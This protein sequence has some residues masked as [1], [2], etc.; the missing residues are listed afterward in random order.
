MLTALDSAFWDQHGCLSSRVHFVETGGKGAHSPVDY[1]QRLCESL[2][3]LS[4]VLPRGSWPRQ[5]IRDRFDKY[6]LLETAGEVAVVSHYEDD[7]LVAVDRRRLGARSFY[8]SVN[9]CQG[10]VILVRPVSELMEVPE[11]YL[12]IV[13]ADNLQSL[14]VAV[15]K[16]GEGLDERFLRFADACANRGITAIRTIGRGAFPQLAYS[17]DGYIPLDLIRRRPKGRFASIEFDAPFE[18][19]MDTFDMFLRKSAE[20]GSV[21]VDG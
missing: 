19:I 6:K 8:D 17:W 13:S 11:Q 9:D 7:Y 1:A 10:R 20:V 3:L 15:G 2:K 14:S 18:Q 12:S 5:Q 4:G 16:A 21:I